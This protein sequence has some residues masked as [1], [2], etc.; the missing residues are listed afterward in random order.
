MTETEALILTSIRSLSEKI[1]A[2]RRDLVAEMRAPREALER[3]P[4]RRK[5]PDVT[6]LLHAI[7]ATERRDSNFTSAEL[8]AHAHLSE[9]ECVALRCALLATVGSLEPKRIGKFLHRIAGRSFGGLSVH[10]LDADRNGAI[11]KIVAAEV[12]EWR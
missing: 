2:L 8:S 5:E 7:V 6:T 4:G 1:D 12:R 11:W 9:P 10:R 3:T